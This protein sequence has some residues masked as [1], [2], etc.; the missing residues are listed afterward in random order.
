MKNRGGENMW[1]SLKTVLLKSLKNQDWQYRNWQS[2]SK[3]FFLKNQKFIMIV[4]KISALWFMMSFCAEASSC[5]ELSVDYTGIIKV[6]EERSSPENVNKKIQSNGLKIKSSDN[7]MFM[8]EKNAINIHVRVRKDKLDKSESDKEG[9]DKEKTEQNEI[10]K[11][12]TEDSL[13]ENSAESKIISSSDSNEITETSE[14]NSTK[15]KIVK[16]FDS[17]DLENIKI[18]LYQ[19]QYSEEGSEKREL[20]EERKLDRED[21]SEDNQEEDFVCSIQN[22]TEGHYKV[23]IRYGE[24]EENEETGVFTV[25]EN[26]EE[27]AGCMKKGYYE[28]PL[29]TVDTQVP[30]IT[31][32]FC[33]R[34]AIR[35]IGER[36]YFQKMPQIVLRI[37][38]ENFNKNCLYLDGKMFYADGETMR[39]EW[40]S[41]KKEIENLH[42]ESYYKNGIR[43]NEARLQA[44]VEANYTLKFRSK[45]GAENV[46][47]LKNLEF[48]Y[49]CTKPEII[50]TGADNVTGNLIFDIVDN[51]TGDLTL[52]MPDNDIS[53]PRLIFRKYQFFRYFSP[54]KM[55]V[56]VKVKD[57]ISGVE[58]IKY[59][60]ISYDGN[61]NTYNLVDPGK[62]ELKKEEYRKSQTMQADN[63]SELIISV[64]PEQDNFKGYLKVYGQDYSENIG[65]VVESKGAISETSQLHKKISDILIKLP[66]AVF[67]DK[68][69]KISYYN[70][71]IPVYASFEDKQSGIYKTSLYAGKNTGKGIG[72]AAM[73]DGETITYKKE[74]KLIL[75]SEEFD[76]SSRGYPLVIEAQMEDN[77]GH[78]DK[79][80]SDSKVVIDTA[81]PEIKVTYD[82][83]EESGCYNVSRKATVTVKEQNFDP[84]LVKWDIW[85]SNQKYHIGEWKEIKGLHTC[86]VSF[87]EEGE[88]YAVNLSVKDLAGNKAEWKDGT[89]FSIDKTAPKISV[90]LNRVMSDLQEEEQ[91]LDEKNQQS[92]DSQHFAKDNTIDGAKYF[93]HKQIVTFCI[94]DRNF[95]EDKVEYNIE[96]TTG[97]K[98]MDIERPGKYVKKG[99]KYYSRLLLEKEAKYHVEVS[100]TDKAG[101]ESEIKKL[102]EFVIDT[103]APRVVVTGIKHNEVYEGGNIIPK[104]LCKDKNLDADTVKFHLCKADGSEVTKKEWRY[105][106]IN[107]ENIVQRQWDNLANERKRDGIYQL[108]VEASDKAGNRLKDS[109]KIVFRVNRWGAEFILDED[110]KQELGR[111]YLKAAPDIILRERC[112]QPTKSRVIILKDNEDREILNSENIRQHVI[113]DKASSRYG[114]YEKIYNVGQKNF[115]KEG[116]YQ[117]SFLAGSKEKNIRFVV[118]KTSPAVNIGNLDEEI[119]EEKEHEFTVSVIDN[120][121]FNKLEL[122]I[123]ESGGVGKPTE[124]KKKI[125]KPEDLDK[126]YTVREKLIKS[127]KKQTIRYVAWDKAGNKTDSE[128]IG[129]TRRC[130]VTDNR[131]LKGYYKHGNT[132]EK[133]NDESIINRESGGAKV[134]GISLL[135]ISMISAGSYLFIRKRIF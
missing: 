49:D 22:L 55:R 128:D 93:N 88:N 123:E 14:E 15:S 67:T 124:V 92:Q 79:K 57:D 19:I 98:R 29:Y 118:D 17:F 134:L 110:T 131:A 78:I 85:G 13:E 81:K 87:E 62:G 11:D 106:E 64:S 34:K 46:S 56:L 101:N 103:T 91:H 58:K 82:C 97:K 84:D 65:D 75:K 25:A 66:K 45:D 41:L 107:S 95:D 126:N 117:I 102:E 114:W 10:N 44:D 3:R 94:Q 26:D 129:D 36:Q 42:W 4:L 100:C 111:Y 52:D 119:Y 1:N 51:V 7:E 133:S 105:E 73:W 53:R 83:N 24:Q 8:K 6:M 89:C 72:T 69:K 12:E 20:V 2:R 32:V 43:I 112:V 121:A 127:G 23:V 108:F 35:K 76:E 132:S 27:T 104:V 60:F 16:N 77:A 115:E 71:N 109:F 28:S 90:Y 47:D 113:A 68:E 61:G 59:D 30:V 54:K 9:I 125:I 122:Y 135:G 5:P 120:Y 48:T 70:K 18:E 37:Q 39:G 86:E 40:Q 38:E 74:Q 130:Y 80:A 33:N 21:L 50:Y 63:L 96:A 99:D 116:D 31:E